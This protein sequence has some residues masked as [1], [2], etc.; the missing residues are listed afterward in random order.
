M[1]GQMQLSASR[2]GLRALYPKWDLTGYVV[3]MDVTLWVHSNIIKLI[4]QFGEDFKGYEKEVF[5]IFPE[6]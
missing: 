3:E 2:Q 6:N 1:M 5:A 4:N